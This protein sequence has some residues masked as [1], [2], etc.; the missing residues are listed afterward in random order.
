MKLLKFEAT[1]QYP[2]QSENFIST[3]TPLPQHESSLISDWLI[4]LYP[5]VNQQ[6][7]EKIPDMSSKLISPYFCILFFEIGCTVSLLHICSLFQCIDFTNKLWYLIML[8]SI[9]RV[10]QTNHLPRFNSVKFLNCRDNLGN[11]LYFEIPFVQKYLMKSFK[12]TIAARNLSRKAILEIF[13]SFSQITN[14]YDFFVKW[15]KE[16][17]V[18]T[19][20]AI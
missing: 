15:T 17:S 10:Q 13:P 8:D 4:L 12:W 5:V 2:S 6:N 20:S 7:W 19:Y 1:F 3:T 9:W 16:F 18:I 11:G 14:C